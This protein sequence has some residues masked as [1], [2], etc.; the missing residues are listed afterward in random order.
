[1]WTLAAGV[2]GRGAARPRARSLPGVDPETLLVRLAQRQGG[3]FTR[4]QAVSCG[5]SRAEIETALRTGRWRTLRYG[6]HVRA[7]D[8]PEQGAPRV[9]LQVQAA[10][11]RLGPSVVARGLTAAALHGLPL[12]DAAPDA[13]DVVLPRREGVSPRRDVAQVWLP[14]EQVVQRSGVPVT[15]LARTAV[16]VARRSPALAGVVVA[17][18]ALLRGATAHDL[19]EA[20]GAVRGSPGRRAAALALDRARAGAE[21]ALETLGRVQMVAQGIP[22]PELQVEVGDADGPIGR[23][24]HLWRE[25]RVIG[26]ADGR[27]KYADLAVLWAE[28]LR[29]DRLRDAGFEVVRYGWHEALHWPERLAARVR[30]AFARSARR[31]R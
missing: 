5:C 2:D 26:E 16:D 1:M 23:V 27:S 4:A 31:P 21:S 30:A 14:P 13:P 18:G 12:L 22:E 17:D 3:V 25:Q 28:K 10:R 11:L 6:V 15:S 29:E 19:A 7:Q 8:V 9:A 24:D 20:L